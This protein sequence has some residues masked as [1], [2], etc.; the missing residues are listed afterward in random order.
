MICKQCNPGFEEPLFDGIYVC[1]VDGYKIENTSGDVILVIHETTF[2]SD[3]DDQTP[4][5][6]AAGDT[7]A[8]KVP[9]SQAD[10][11]RAITCKVSSGIPSAVG[12]G[13]D[14]VL[15]EIA[16]IIDDND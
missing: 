7:V 4:I 13:G 10:D 2:D 9:V 6:L 12:A 15:I 11:W 14:D 8:L 1:R 3:D 5:F 16:A